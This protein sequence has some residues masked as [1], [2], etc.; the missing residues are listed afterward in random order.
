MAALPAGIRLNLR[1]ELS[2]R[3]PGSVRFCVVSDRSQG[4]DP[5]RRG[6]VNLERHAP[7][8][9]VYD[10][11]SK[12]LADWSPGAGSFLLVATPF[13]LAQAQ[14]AAGAPFVIGLTTVGER[15]TA[16]A[17]SPPRNTP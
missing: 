11:G 12:H 3:R 6:N 5:T 15:R 17:S 16:P 2:G 1:A 7:F 8:Q 4:I 14:G 9:L 13:A 10:D